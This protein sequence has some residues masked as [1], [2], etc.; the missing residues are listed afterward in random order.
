MRV[1][2]LK[3]NSQV[4]IIWKIIKEILVLFKVEI[5]DEDYQYDSLAVENTE[6]ATPDVLTT[7]LILTDLKGEVRTFQRTSRL[8]AGESE[9]AGRNRLIKVNLYRIFTEE[10]KGNSA[11]W[12]VLHGVRPTKI[13]HRYMQ[14]EPDL[15]KVK[16][17]FAEDYLVSPEKT[18]LIAEIAEL[19]LPFLKEDG[20]KISIYVGIPFCPSRCL[21]CSFPSMILPP[22]AIVDK[23]LTALAKEIETIAAYIR[24]YDLTVQSIYVGGGTPTS[25]KYHELQT[26]L[27]LIKKHFYGKDV[28]EYTVEAGRPDAIDVEKIKLLASYGVDR[29]S[30][31]PQTMRDSTLKLIGRKHTGD[32]IRRAFSDVRQGGIEHINADLIIGLPNEGVEDARYS[33]EELIKLKPVDITLHALALKKGSALK[34]AGAQIILPDDATVQAMSEVMVKAIK[35]YGLHPYYIYRQGYMS[36]QLENVGYC[37][38]GQEGIYNIKIMGEQQTI[39]GVGAAATTKIV[40]PGARLMTSFNPKDLPTYF[41]SLDNYLA[42]R[43]ELLAAAYSN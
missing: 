23:Y 25:L 24:E 11:P 40:K 35:A 31:N 14:Q 39:L 41:N 33:I 32:D 15:Q 30:V 10:L 3:I 38:P 13:L 6:G 9:K 22:E 7:K 17:A 34:M 37:R 1:R 27:E 21:Y 5:T 19:Q 2:E 20:K 4:E 29:V 28:E 8:K 12:G 43:K 16:Q 36:G 26:V 18:E 42:K